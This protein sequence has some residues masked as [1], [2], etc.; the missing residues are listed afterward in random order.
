MIAALTLLTGI[1]A[2]VLWREDPVDLVT[3]ADLVRERAADN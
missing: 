2:S 3:L 1:P